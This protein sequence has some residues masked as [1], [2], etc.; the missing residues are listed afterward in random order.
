MQESRLFALLPEEYVCTPDGMEIDRDGNLIVSCPNYADDN[1]S[2]CVIRIDKEKNISKWFDVPVH[3]ETGIAR[4]MG[5][6]FDSQW[7][8]FICDNQPWSGKEELAWKGRMLKVIFDEEGK[9]KDWYTVADGMEHPNGVRI[10]KNYMYVTQSYLTKVKDESGNL[11][12]CVYRFPLDARDIAITNT[13]E[14]EYI[15]TTFVTNNPRCQYGADGIEIDSKGNMYVGNFG[16]GEVWKIRLDENGDM[17]DKEVYAR[18]PDELVS[19]DGMIMD[20]ATGNLYI[21][22]FNNNAIVMVDKDR[23]VRRIA[24]SPDCDGF[25]GEL[26]QPG[27]PII[28]QGKI[29]ASCFDLVTDETK[30]NTQHEMPAT[31][32]ELDLEP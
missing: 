18:N 17:I 21:A 7:N 11:V 25:H 16:D 14:D 30:V 6:A 26:D 10:Y 5:I 8:M 3:P 12:S 24:Q 2:G 23:N 15:F 31:M 20:E 4:N 22:D 19:T 27:E 13:L 28:W 29:V 32:A 1:M 9:V